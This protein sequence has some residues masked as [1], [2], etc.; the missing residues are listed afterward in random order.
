[1]R[2]T[3][4]PRASSRS[5]VRWAEKLE[6]HST[7]RT[8]FPTAE[9][10]AARVGSDSS[11]NS[12]SGGSATYGRSLSSFSDV[13]LRIIQGLRQWGEKDLLSPKPTLNKQQSTTFNTILL[14]FPVVETGFE[15]LRELFT[16]VDEDKNGSIEYAEFDAAIRFNMGMG[17]LPAEMKKQIWDEVNVDKNDVIDFKE[18]IMVVA[19]LYLMGFFDP[20]SRPSSNV[21]LQELVDSSH[22]SLEA[23]GALT[24]P[25]VEIGG[26]PAQLL[27]DVK[28]ALDVVI[29]AFR[30][31]DPNGSG[32]LVQREVLQGFE[33]GDDRGGS[34][35][36]SGRVH[37]AFFKNR[38]AEMELDGDGVISF[39]E[40]LYA[41]EGWVG[42]DEGSGGEDDE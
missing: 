16:L 21:D 33:A 6:E 29:A 30:M 38:I 13:E 41:F 9:V 42:I 8:R 24:S 34:K 12:G 28:K 2:A 31:F 18:F 3:D 25:H 5:S 1:M 23:D 4:S 17:S 11:R 27:G 26:D 10:P 20:N 40:F 15:K 22:R 36:K 35:S 14:K 19:C 37:G 32:Y 39:G 7:G